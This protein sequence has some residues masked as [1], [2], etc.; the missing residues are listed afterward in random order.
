VIFGQQLRD[1]KK[2]AAFVLGTEAHQ[3]AVWPMGSRAVWVNIFFTNFGIRCQS[4]FHPRQLPRE[5]IF[6]GLCQPRLD[7]VLN[8][9]VQLL[10]DSKKKQIE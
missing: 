4:Q 7:T 6:T 10:V 1:M 5:T 3:P 2:A 9:P 8:E